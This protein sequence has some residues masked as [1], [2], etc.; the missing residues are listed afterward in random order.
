MLHILLLLIIISYTELL[1]YPKHFGHI[2]GYTSVTHQNTFG[3]EATHS[4]FII[5]ISS[6]YKFKNIS[7]NCYRNFADLT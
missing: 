1:T 7:C 2:F 6:S 3:V 4:T 5:L